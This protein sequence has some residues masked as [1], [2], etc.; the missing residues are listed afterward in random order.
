MCVLKFISHT[1]IFAQRTRR[2]AVVSYEPPEE[3]QLSVMNLALRAHPEVISYQIEEVIVWLGVVFFLGFL[4]HMAVPFCQL[5][6]M[7][8]T[9][10]KKS[11]C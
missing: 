5:Q 7:L 6:V 8:T 10:I 9:S 2:N 4:F 3:L 11:Y 1:H